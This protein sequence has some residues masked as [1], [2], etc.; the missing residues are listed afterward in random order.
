[1]SEVDQTAIE[2]VKNLQSNIR[3]ITLAMV[4]ILLIAVLGA[5]F[6]GGVIDNKVYNNEKSIDDL[7]EIV[8]EYIKE[9]RM[10]RENYMKRTDI[11]PF[12]DAWNEMSAN[13]GHISYWAES[14]GY[15]PLSRSQIDAIKKTNIN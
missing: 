14:Q 12:Q 11:I 4:G 1:M 6:W 7:T 3:N 5:V 2:M 10:A 13:W 15:N 9:S 8:S